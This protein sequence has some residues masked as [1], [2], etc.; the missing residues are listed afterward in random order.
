MVST[1]SAMATDLVWKE[2]MPSWVP[3]VSVIP[4]QSSPGFP[5]P[6]PIA[7]P[8]YGYQ[9]APQPASGFPLIPPSLH[10]AL[11]LLFSWL[12]GGLFQVIWSFVQA[13]FA[14]KID[15]LNR[16]L[17]LL[18]FAIL[19]GI[20]CIGMFIVGAVASGSSS[21]VGA[22]QAGLFGLAFLVEIAAIVCLY[23]ANFKMRR[24]M[25]NYY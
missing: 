11:V 10:W 17:S 5:P 7:Q 21:D 16:S 2:G 4:A 6:L 22:A 18:I 24:S 15:P 12:T 1:G 13:G 25:V 23:A 19:G 20:G 3:L 9:S 14:K 8:V